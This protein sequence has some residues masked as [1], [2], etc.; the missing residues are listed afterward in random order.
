MQGTAGQ[1]PNTA[2]SRP[3]AHSPAA[4]VREG[5]CETTR[6]H[7]CEPVKERQAGEGESKSVIVAQSSEGARLARI[8][9]WPKVLNRTEISPVRL[10]SLSRITLLSCTLHRLLPPLQHAIAHCHVAQMLRTSA[11]LSA[12]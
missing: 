6:G 12:Q 10:R 3:R 8:A 7:A 5:E 9:C 1:P 4:V 2:L 11:A